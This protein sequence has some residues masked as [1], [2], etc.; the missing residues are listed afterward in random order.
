[1]L[2]RS[3]LDTRALKIYSQ[4]R[5]ECSKGPNERHGHIYGLR[6]KGQH[7]EVPL[8]VMVAHP[9][10]HFVVHF[11]SFILFLL[12]FLKVRFM[13]HIYSCF[14]SQLFIN[15]FHCLFLIVLVRLPSHDNRFA[16]GFSKGDSASR[17]HYTFKSSTYKRRLTGPC[18]PCR[19]N[20]EESGFD[21]INPILCINFVVTY[22]KND[23]LL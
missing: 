2:L 17:A 18:W 22:L 6:K 14:V 16:K 8:S 9:Q 15:D 19:T 20:S 12:L 21:V 5:E 23:Q 10:K 1:M 3:K 7:I 11:K 13:S 4:I